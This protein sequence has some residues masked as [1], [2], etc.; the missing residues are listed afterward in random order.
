MAVCRARE[1]PRP[2]QERRQQHWLFL[3]ISVGFEC[4]QLVTDLGGQLKIQEVR[5][6]NV[7]DIV[8]LKSKEFDQEYWENV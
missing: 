2:W 1:L 8:L 3:H 5:R 7:L 6:A 4:Q